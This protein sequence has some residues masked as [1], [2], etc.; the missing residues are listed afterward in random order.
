MLST[1]PT[2]A[3]IA[4]VGTD[5][6][7]ASDAVAPVDIVIWE[8]LNLSPSVPAVHNGR[9]KD[10]C[11]HRHSGWP[12]RCRTSAPVTPG[13]IGQ[14]DRHHDRV[15]RLSAVWHGYRPR[16]RQAVFP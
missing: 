15:V 10:G 8:Q 16:V 2:H 14:H 3:S 1:F 13:F 7:S 9:N 11:A 4:L 6:Q 12:F 5:G